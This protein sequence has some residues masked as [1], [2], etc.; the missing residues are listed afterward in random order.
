ME[1]WRGLDVQ[2]HR[3]I[4]N[5]SVGGGI[6]KCGGCSPAPKVS[7]PILRARYGWSRRQYVADPT[8]DFSQMFST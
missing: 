3:L 6:M 1:A 7:S 4:G 8:I 5:G 2:S